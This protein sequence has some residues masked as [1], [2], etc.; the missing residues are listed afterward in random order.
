MFG[1]MAG[2]ALG[3]MLV[4]SVRLMMLPFRL[5]FTVRLPAKASTPVRA[6]VPSS[7][8]RRSVLSLPELRVK[9]AALPE[10]DPT[11]LAIIEMFSSQGI[12]LL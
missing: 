9:V 12:D 2:R 10:D 5:A 3:A 4:W 1:Y 11:R 8:P 6:S 7:S